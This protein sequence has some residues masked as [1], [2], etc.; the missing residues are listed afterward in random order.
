MKALKGKLRFK[1]GSETIIWS[2]LSRDQ[3]ILS[4]A[5]ISMF[6]IVFP[7]TIEEAKEETKPSLS[8]RKVKK[9][10]KVR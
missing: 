2:A 7:A 1:R 3:I 5:D 9:P 10:S 8:C 6:K 4:E